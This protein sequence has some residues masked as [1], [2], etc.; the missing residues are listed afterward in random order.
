MPNITIDNYTECKI[1]DDAQYI[2][3]ILCNDLVD[4]DR[5]NDLM[6]TWYNA[7]SDEVSIILDFGNDFLCNTKDGIDKHPNASEIIVIAHCDTQTGASIGN[8]KPEQYFDT[9]TF[10]PILANILCGEDEVNAKE[11]EP[12]TLYFLGCNARLFCG[13]LKKKLK[14]KGVYNITIYAY[15]DDDFNINDDDDA[16][17]KECVEV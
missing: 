17:K 5:L 13:N 10:I 3:V 7:S 12:V 14:E 15:Q 9:D 1:R 16:I 4:P 2:G 6:K 11:I 8:N